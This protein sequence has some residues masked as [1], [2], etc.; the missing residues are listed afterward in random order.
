MNEFHRDVLQPE[1]EEL[2]PIEM[3]TPRL[4]GLDRLPDPKLTAQGWKRRFMADSLRL[5]DYLEL[6]SS[7]GFEVRSETVQPA[8]I[9]PECND[10][11]ST[12]CRQ[13]VTLYTRRT[14]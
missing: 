3:P 6:Y 5:S 13:F 14:E 8:D 4:P 2:C 11:R 9:G 7:L 10:C 12:L 1:D